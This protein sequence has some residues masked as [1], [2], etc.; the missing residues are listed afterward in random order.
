MLLKSLV[1]TVFLSYLCTFHFSQAWII[2]RAIDA[3]KALIEREEALLEQAKV[4][5]KDRTD[6]A[7]NTVKEGLMNVGEQILYYV[8][9]PV[10]LGDQ[11]RQGSRGMINNARSM[12]Q[13]YIVT[14]LAPRFTETGRSLNDTSNMPLLRINESPE[15]SSDSL[16][17][18]NISTN[19][20][21]DGSLHEITS[22]DAETV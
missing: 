3:Q 16:T 11:V 19:V 13:Q 2:T 5:V 18:D 6:S 20:P 1:I 21:S 15:E 4:A 22:N 7:L 10:R 17:T 14:S 8:S 9:F 12:L